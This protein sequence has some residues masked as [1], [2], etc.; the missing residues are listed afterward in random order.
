MVCARHSS[1]QTQAV[2]SSPRRKRTG[3][4]SQ[5]GTCMEIAEAVLM[6]RV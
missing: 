5:I 2:S 1:R 3:L 6:V 4:P